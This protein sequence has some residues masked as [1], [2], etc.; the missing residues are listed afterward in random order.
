MKKKEMGPNAEGT[1]ED[2]EGRVE[3]GGNRTHT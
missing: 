1:N 3:G 2:K